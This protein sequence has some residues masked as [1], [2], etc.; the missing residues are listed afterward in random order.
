MN[1]L[2]VDEINGIERFAILA[3][4]DPSACKQE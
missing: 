1:R 3:G 2:Y 4:Q